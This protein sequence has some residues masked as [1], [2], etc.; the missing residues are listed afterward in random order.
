MREDFNGY[1]PTPQDWL[2]HIPFQPWMTP[3]P[4]H[5]RE[6]MKTIEA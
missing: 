6:L 5:Q 3:S 1:I 4:A 2:K